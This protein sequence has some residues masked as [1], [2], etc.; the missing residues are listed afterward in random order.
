MPGSAI[1]APNALVRAV[2]VLTPAASPRAGP[3]SAA[4]ADAQRTLAQYL[5]EPAS[6]D[7]AYRV[8]RGAAARA[9]AAWRA[10]RGAP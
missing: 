4:E 1:P 5:D 10:K 3:P 2:A 7:V 9:R 8:R 6:A